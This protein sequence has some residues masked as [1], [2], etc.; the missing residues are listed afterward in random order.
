MRYY[1]N[2][3]DYTIDYEKQVVIINPDLHEKMKNKLC[4]YPKTNFKYGYKKIGGSSLGDILNITKFSSPFRAF[5]GYAYLTPK[6]LVKKYINAGIAI[7]PKVIN[8]LRETLNQNRNEEDYVLV[9]GIRSEDYGYNYFKD[10]DE[11][12]NGVPDGFLTTKDKE[13]LLEIKTANIKNFS[14]W[15][16]SVPQNYVKQAQLYSYILNI[17]KFWI[18]ATFLNE[19]DYD[20]PENYDIKNRKLKNWSFIVNKDEAKDDME[21]AKKWYR[22]FVLNGVSPRFEKSR[23]AELLE[24]LECENEEE[25]IFLIQKWKKQGKCDLD[26]EG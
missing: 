21:Y 14:Y 16:K 5:C 22:E 13:I 20:D 12:I 18:V 19:Q 11:L 10:Y 15:Q 6:P 24:F 9:R 25:W 7:E 2:K 8:I 1:Y 4:V 26:Y 3:K 23:D 17:E